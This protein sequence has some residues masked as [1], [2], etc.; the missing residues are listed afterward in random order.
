M[1]TCD[2]AR[3]A[4]NNHLLGLRESQ[5]KSKELQEKIRVDMM[6][7]EDQL[8]ASK[9]QVRELTSCTSRINE[10]HA[11]TLASKERGLIASQSELTAASNK[12]EAMK[13]QEMEL[14]ARPTRRWFLLESRS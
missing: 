13:A 11:S 14:Q 10:T 2:S 4:G 9:E 7:L 6:G 1:R 3:R 5:A 12:L 8:A